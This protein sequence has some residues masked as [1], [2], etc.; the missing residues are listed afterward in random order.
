MITINANSWESSKLA[1]E[2]IWSDGYAPSVIAVQETK[3]PVGKLSWFASYATRQGYRHYGTP[4]A[5][6]AGPGAY[7]G[8]VSLLV[9]R[10]FT[11]RR[12]QLPPT[13]ESRVVAVEVN[14][15]G[16]K[17]IF[18]SVYFKPSVA[19]DSP[20]MKDFFGVLAQWLMEKDT[21]FVLAGDWNVSPQELRAHTWVQ[22]LN[23]SIVHPNAVTCDQGQGTEIDFYVVS[24]AMAD[25][26]HRTAVIRG[27]PTWPHRPV[28]V[29]FDGIM[30]K[31]WNQE[32][33]RIKSFPFELPIGCAEDYQEPVFEESTNALDMW[34]KWVHVL[35]KRLCHLHGFK[36][37][38]EE[39]YAGR[40]A[41]PKLQWVS[42]KQAVQSGRMKN[43]SHD[44]RE[45][46]SVRG[47]V[48]TAIR[49]WRS[50]EKRRD[51]F[52]TACWFEKPQQQEPVDLELLVDAEQ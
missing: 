16:L 27:G 7:S 28:A 41:G 9:D 4:A 46:L 50:L 22:L 14:M 24:T 10:R 8:G 48:R 6:G 3:L 18:L 31:C 19:L 26:M 47:L 51:H 49:L 2:Q 36:D 52:E 15:F 25:F 35:E 33:V 11:S 40:N 17:I 1:L 39:K 43:A 29:L 37:R 23:A 44:L 30:Q 34:K 5:Q 42:L 32:L 38:G 12:L 21:P 45:T 13:S 20:E